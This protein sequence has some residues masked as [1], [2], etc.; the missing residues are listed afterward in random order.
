MKDDKWV[1]EDPEFREIWDAASEKTMTSPARGYALY[2]A[3]RYL[4]ENKIV[5]SIVECGVWRGGSALIILKTLELV[6]PTARDVYLFDTFEGMTAPGES[7]VDLLGRSAQSL[8][9]D[10]EEGRDK[11]LVW[12]RASEEDVRATL[13]LSGYDK[14]RV[15]LIKGDVRTVLPTIQ[16]GPIALLRLDTDFFDSTLVELEELY[17]RLQKNGVMIIDDYGH[18]KGCRIAVDQYL[19]TLEQG[20]K[21]LLQPVDYTGR[22]AIKTDE[23]TKPLIERY[24]YVPPGLAKIDLSPAFENLRPGD[25]TRINWPYLR[26]RVPHI[27]RSDADEKLSRIGVLSVEE[28]LLLHNLALPFRGE[29]ALEVGCHVGWSTAHLVA[30]GLRLDVIDPILART[31][32]REAIETALDRDTGQGEARL[33]PGYSP[34]IVD[35]VRSTQKADWSFAFIDGNHDEDAP[36]S[37]AEAVSK[38]MARKAV[39]VFHDLTSPHV[40][41]GLRVFEA[42]GWSIGLYNTMQVLG[43]AWRG[44]VRLPKHVAD[45]NVPVVLPGHLNGIRMLSQS[46]E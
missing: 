32:I 37:D 40:A 34:W 42:Q 41:A 14:R 28:A 17:P 22:L 21:P 13:E 11:E 24:D 16:T 35:A 8:M 27:W 33:W 43:V 10:S 5:G 46:E 36:A 39:V 3:V 9:Y 15:H 20:S 45:R 4:V 44:N 7:D 30:A 25:P 23:P 29:R 6:G 19:A 26:H 2:R 38:H 18:W 1:L 31:N 12:A